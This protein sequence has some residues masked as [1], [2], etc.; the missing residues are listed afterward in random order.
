MND[1]PSDPVIRDEVSSV[2]IIFKVPQ[3]QIRDV[4]ITFPIAAT[5]EEV[6]EGLERDHISHPKVHQSR[7]F[8]AGKV[9]SNAD[10]L[11]SILINVS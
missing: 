5:I 6:K 1:D 11:E 8:R 9:L 7:L 4:E 3:E 10:V 2:T